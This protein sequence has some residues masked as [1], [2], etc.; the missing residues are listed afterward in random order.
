MLAVAR[1]FPSPVPIKWY[2]TAAESV[3]LPD[4]SFD[5]V[6]CQLGLQFIADRAAAVREIHRV[7]K[8]GGRL[9]INTPLPNAFFDALERGIRRHLSEEASMFV[10]A[11][12]SLNDPQEMQ[13]LLG[14]AGLEIESI[15][16]HVKRL[17]L[18][19][20]RDFMWQYIYST[21]LMALL[22]Q[23]GNAQTE[24]LER[25]VVAAWKP[26]VHGDGMSCEQAVLVSVARRP[27]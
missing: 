24:A 6:F 15:G 19:A 2:E 13:D 27:V 17:Q 1:T 18:P 4:K 20:A 26:W 21:P 3:P 8:P 14:G 23:S 12:F 5:V 7:L 10:H 9:Y 11:V 22:P 25:D 16:P